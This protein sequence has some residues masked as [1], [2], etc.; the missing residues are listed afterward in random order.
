MMRYIQ[1]ILTVFLF[2]G[3]HTL[4]AYGQARPSVKKEKIPFRLTEYNN[5]VI[6]A[7]LNGRDT[8]DLMLHTAASDMTLTK[9]GS[10]RLVTV[11]FEGA[12]DSVQSW[13]GNS[14]TSAVSLH[15]TL[16]I[17][18]SS[19]SDMTIFQNENSGQY[20]DGKFGINIFSNKVLEFDFRKKVLIIR[21]KLPRKVKSYEQFAL[22]SEYDQLYIQAICQIENNTYEN[23]YLIH[24][25]YAG[26]IML[27]D[28]FAQS[29][30]IGQQI[31]IVGEKK[32][33]DSF[34][35]VLHTKNGIMPAFLIGK[36]Q[37]TNI[38][39]GFFEGATVMQSTSILGGD[40]LKR[41]NWIID[42]ER[43]YIYLKKNALFDT[44][45]WGSKP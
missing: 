2:T 30:H 42:A 8:V 19:W 1:L 43:K 41:F 34:G 12:A 29:N 32:L 17:G 27:D 38:P 21:D 35:N 24:S 4:V 20:T 6:K 33:T 14:N 25:G 15:N 36:F 28:H 31:P 10:A 26:T 22:R 45:F 18:S 40:V 23:S 7:L 9:S 5:I 37:L 3:I 44:P 39:A 11:K 13:G 16:Q